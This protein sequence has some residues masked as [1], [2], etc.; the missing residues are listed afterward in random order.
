MDWRWLTASVWLFIWRWCVRTIWNIFIVL[1]VRTRNT[2]TK[3]TNGMK[4][5]SSFIQNL[6][7]THN[8]TDKIQIT[9]VA[10]KIREM[11]I[12]ALYRYS[13]R[14]KRFRASS[15]RKLEREQNKEW[16]GRGRGVKERSKFRA[17]IRLETLVTQ[18]IC[19]RVKVN[20][21]SPI[22]STEQSL[23]VRNKIHDKNSLIPS[24]SN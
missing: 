11:M 2:T 7:T 18:A 13:L 21:K 20:V 15:S 3:M 4:N 23:N 19:S 9:R 16:R 22:Y 14:S 8:I 5:H 17:I 12:N 1:T 24:R 6:S 10:C